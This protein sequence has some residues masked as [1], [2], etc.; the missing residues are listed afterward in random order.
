MTYEFFLTRLEEKIR[1]W[2]EEGE[3]ICRVQVLKNNSVKL[4]GF[5]LC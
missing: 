5:L 1:E 4:D 3:K 2:Q